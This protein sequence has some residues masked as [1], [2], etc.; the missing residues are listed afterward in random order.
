MRRH[1][2]KGRS[3]TVLWVFIAFIILLLIIIAVTQWL[4]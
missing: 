4:A 3:D 2:S 1:P